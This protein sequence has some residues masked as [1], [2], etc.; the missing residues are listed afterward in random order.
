V[1]PGTTPAGDTISDLIGAAL[2]GEPGTSAGVAVIGL[3]SATGGQWQYSHDGGTTWTPI[4]SAA[5]SAALLLAGIDRVR[6][7][8][9]GTATGTVTLQL[10]AW[11]GSSGQEGHTVDLSTA[12]AVGGT[13]AFSPTLATL[14]AVVNT[15]PTLSLSTGPTE[16]DLSENTPSSPVLKVSSLLAK[17]FHDV[18]ARALQ[19]VA[20]VGATG[21]GSWQYSLDGKHWLNLGAVSDTSAL[22]LTSTARLR[23]LPTLG[24]SGAVTLTYRAWDQTGGMTGSLLALPGTG[25]AWPFSPTTASIHFNVSGAHQKPVLNTT[26]PF[27]LTPVVPGTTPTGQTIASLLGNAIQVAGS[28]AAPGIAITGLTGTQTGSWQ[29]STDGVHWQS[30]SPV[31]AHSPRL[32]P[33]TD[34]VRYLPNVGFEG[35]ATF[36]FKAWDQTSTTAG[37]AF[38]KASGKA[39]VLVNNAP[40]VKA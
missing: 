22:L 3:T 17:L 27:A 29:F 4:T 28:G 35:T 33:A 7:L 1:A 11:D 15:A 18:D 38:S 5:P 10:R 9:N 6:Y 21:P 32:L 31:S 13:T 14:T 8:P 25:G 26:Q 40:V 23:F 19:G 16:R 30:L 39:T 36:S 12:S 24:K 37:S 2:V 20:V 34:W